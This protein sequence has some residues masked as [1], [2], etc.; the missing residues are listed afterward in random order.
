MK[1]CN[2]CRKI[3]FIYD[4]FFGATSFKLSRWLVVMPHTVMV[5]V[6]FWGCQTTKPKDSSLSLDDLSGDW[7]EDC[8]VFQQDASIHSSDVV[9]HIQ[10][11]SWGAQYRF[12]LDN[13]CQNLAFRLMIDYHI[14]VLQQD[15]TA[16]R[17]PIELEPHRYQLVMDPQIPLDLKNQFIAALPAAEQQDGSDFSSFMAASTGILG[18]PQRSW[19]S[20]EGDSFRKG[21]GEVDFQ[22]LQV[23]RSSPLHLFN[24]V[25]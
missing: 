10:G 18:L 15:A 14:R 25:K 17:I 8:Q 20:K 3:R 19:L 6:M 4:S 22:T 2:L 12:F 21:D 24:K 16:D 5:S 1:I 11:Q 7:R 23:V 9:V 13:Q